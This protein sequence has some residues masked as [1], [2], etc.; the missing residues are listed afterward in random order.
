M[1]QD[2]QDALRK[3]ML[4]FK[5]EEIK[6]ALVKAKDKGVDAAKRKASAGAGGASIT[7]SGADLWN[8]EFCFTSSSSAAASAA[9]ST[10]RARAGSIH[11]RA[12]RSCL[13][14]G[15]ETKEELYD[16]P[17]FIAERIAQ[18]PDRAARLLAMLGKGL[19]MTTD[20][21]GMDCPVEAVTQ[22]E[23]AME[24]VLGR[25]AK[26]PGSEFTVT[27]ACEN[28]TLPQKVL[29]RLRDLRC[30]GCIFSDLMDRVPAAHRDSIKQMLPGSVTSPERCKAAYEEIASYVMQH[31]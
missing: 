17:T 9:V 19:R 12:A 16:W 7:G 29:R 13:P 22:L 2:A 1:A 6:A 8:E 31:R 20:Y 15:P 14:L 25:K 18:D 10:K 30:Y 4:T 3:T 5:L 24:N 28:D 27:H 23:T 26:Q 11:D 21:S